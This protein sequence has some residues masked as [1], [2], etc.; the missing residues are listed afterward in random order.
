[1][2]AR[3]PGKLLLSGAYAVLEG[4]PALVAAV[5]RY[6]IAD[7]D[8]TDASPMPEVRAAVDDP[9]FVDV[10]QLREG[11]DKLGLGSSAAATVAAL[12]VRQAERGND[13]DDPLL[14]QRLMRQAW[15]AHARVQGGGS[16]VDVAA[17]TFG[18]A[19][20]YVKGETPT[21]VTLPRSLVWSVF[22]SGKSARTSELRA[23]VDAL[24]TRDAAR[25]TESI[26]KLAD[27][28][29]Q[30]LDACGADDARAFVRAARTTTSA[31]SDLGAAADAPIVTAEAAELAKLAEAEDAAFMPSGAGGGDCSIFFGTSRPSPS[32]VDR[33][34][35][36]SQSMLTGIALDLRGVHVSP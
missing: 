2:R 10:S 27:A 3:A 13:L 35:R 32:F 16:G 26:R 8:K 22:F 21:P 20:R 1:M 25:W 4:A 15:D 11:N 30:A 28:S 33:A 12:A 23:K 36:L 6:A 34:T 29:T 19:L 9:P 31:L 7:G 5:D 14:R 24:R 17:S 18:G